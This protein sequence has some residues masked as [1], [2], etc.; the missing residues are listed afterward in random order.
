MMQNANITLNPHLPGKSRNQQEEDAFHREAGPKFKEETS[1][2]LHLEHMVL[3]R[4]HFGKQIRN[5]WKILKFWCWRRM[6][7]ISWTDRVRNHKV[8]HTVKENRNIIHI[9][10][11]RETNWIGLILCRNCLLKHVIEGKVERGI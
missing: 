11:R 4:G 7:K 8:L 5:T 2:V 1:E 6:E 9:I 10:N 3:K